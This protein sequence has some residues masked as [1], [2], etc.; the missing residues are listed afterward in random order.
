MASSHSALRIRPAQICATREATGC[1]PP[2]MEKIAVKAPGS[3]S[4]TEYVT[5]VPNV[6]A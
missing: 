2:T 5:V 3:R 1:K 6:S 4:L